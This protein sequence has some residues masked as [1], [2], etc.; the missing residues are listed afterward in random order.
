VIGRRAGALFVVVLLGGCAQF[1]RRTAAP[2]A[3]V[4][5]ERLLASIDERAAALRTFRALAQMHY[6][7]PK[8]SL[9]IKEV[10]AIRRPDHLRIE[11]MSPFG[12]ALQIATDGQRLFAYHHGERTFYG[13]RASAENLA[14]FTR[15]DLELAEVIDMLIG[16]PPARERRGAPSIVFERPQGWWKVTSD[17]VRGGTLVLWFDPESLLAMRASEIERGGIVRYVAQYAQYETMAGVALPRDVR[18]EVPGQQ[19]KIDLRYSN[20][21]VNAELD[22]S[23]FAFDP[24]PGA[25]IVDLDSLDV[26]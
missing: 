4:S 26:G 13:G 11:M 8:E 16:L 17:L 9:A 24:P 14:R 6:V 3:P 2:P 15:L 18:F 5:A 22:S 1:T 25:K 19:A 21:S 7:G 10:I 12:V 20:V 23:L